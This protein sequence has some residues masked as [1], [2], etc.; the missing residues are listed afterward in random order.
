M[1]R[2]LMAVCCAAGFSCGIAPAG[3]EPA[4][5]AIRTT[6][7]K[8]DR[9]RYRKSSPYPETIA[10]VAL[11]KNE[12]PRV[13]EGHP[14]FFV[15]AK[16]WKGGLSVEQ[17]RERAKKE[18]WSKMVGKWKRPKYAVNCSLYYLITKDDSVIP[19]LVKEVMKAKP[20][21]KCG[22]GLV[23]ACLVYDRIANSPKLTEADRK[24]MRE[25]IAATAF[26]CAK[27]QEASDAGDMWHHR[28]G[29]GWIMDVLA[30]GLVLWG[31]HPEAKRLVAWG[32]GY[33][34]NCYFRG[35]A[36]CQGD[37]MGGGHRYYRA[38]AGKLP[39]A[40]ALFQSATED[41][42]AEEIR[43]KHNDF[44]QGNMYAMMYQTLP[45]KTRVESTGF[46]RAARHLT[47][48]N[49]MITGWMYKN[50]DAYAYMRWV[51]KGVRGAQDPK[52]HILLYDEEVD[53]KAAKLSLSGPSSRMWGGSGVGW[54]GYVQMRSAGWAKD[55]TVI[56]FKCG[57]RFWSHGFNTNQNSFYIYR[58]GR[59]APHTGFYNDRNKDGGYQYFG[60]HMRNYYEQTVASN[61]MLIIDPKEWCHTRKQILSNQDKDG[62]YPVYGSQRT[63]RGGS[64]CF[65]FEKFM[66]RMK[67]GGTSFDCADILA[68]EHA[69]D[70][71]YTYTSGDATKAYNSPGYLYSAE[72]RTNRPKTDMF[73]RS[74]AWLDN[75]YLVV[76]DRVN[77]LDAS[78]RK[79]WLL[80]SLGKPKVSGKMIKAKVPGHIEDFDGDLVT[81]DWQGKYIPT[82]DPENPGRLFSRT[83]LPKK[84]YIRRIGGKGHEFWA[85]G[86]NWEPLTRPTGPPNPKTDQMDVGEWRVEVSPAEP[87]KFD[88]FLHLL[89]PCDKSTAKMPEAGMVESAG[90][91]MV[92]LAVGG[93]LVMFG[94]KGAVKGEVVYK[95][96]KG[97]TEHLVVDL[98][99]GAKYAVAGIAGGKKEM[100][101]SSQGTLRF[102]TEGAGSVKLAPVE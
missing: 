86:V 9:H 49:Y 4:K 69:P 50:P 96:P 10:E 84:R 92:G 99:R 43:T 54:F 53:K 20:A 63:H 77:A 14:K 34:K 94:R 64:N 52:A 8:W 58:K 66:G 24:K 78:F 40:I 32:A 36:R 60:Q 3:E 30:A 51:N 26:K 21:F 2:F 91:D 95:A 100:T 17:L 59:L 19:D 89:Y 1:R 82:T 87:A 62:F 55:S 46:D 65:S 7:K 12:M 41:D 88:N 70:F 23:D 13:I 76:F 67:P 102:A 85:G 71:S 45:D 18:P 47:K 73:Q 98:K 97:K 48:G 101:T 31:E 37:H 29:A 15:R 79:V 39:Y 83:F 80:H 57:D 68:F 27:A 25:H 74:L 61:S 16:P 38:G 44:L 6:W 22:G 35:W 28:G 5:V 42:I 11:E 56:E 90:K 75:K 93:W 72:G 33:M 81:I